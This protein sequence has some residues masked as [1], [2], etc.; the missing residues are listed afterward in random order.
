M[1]DRAITA[2]AYLALG[3]NLEQP[4]EQIR[5]AVNR[6]SEL[7]GIIITGRSSLY[8]SK[9]VGFDAQP[10]FINA[11]ICV[12]TPLLPEDLLYRL[13]S[14]EQKLGRTRQFRNAPRTIDIDILLYN[15]VMHNSPQLIL[16]H[17]RMH[18]RAFVL[19]PLLEI[20]PDIHIPGHGT[21][22]ALLTAVREQR[23]ER[24]SDPVLLP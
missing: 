19:R 12:S 4:T 8:R 9:P 1:S 23:I 11:V 7:P 5:Q 20:A 21:A 14:I 18:E 13:L 24:L 16:P 15:Q 3:S 10:D 17:P 6:I 22:S 2:S